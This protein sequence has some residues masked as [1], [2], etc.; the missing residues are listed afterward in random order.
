MADSINAIINWQFKKSHLKMKIAKKKKMKI[1]IRAK[2]NVCNCSL[3]KVQNE[4]HSANNQGQWNMAKMPK[5]SCFPAIFINSG[6]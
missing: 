1:G 6:S 3:I 4:K 5:S 2:F